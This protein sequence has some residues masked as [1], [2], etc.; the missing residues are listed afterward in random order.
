MNVLLA[1]NIYAYMILDCGFEEYFL[2]DTPET[3]FENETQRNLLDAATI[4]G[5]WH[6]T[7]GENSDRT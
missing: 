5:P 4:H 7:G 2:P 6:G 1:L 3:R